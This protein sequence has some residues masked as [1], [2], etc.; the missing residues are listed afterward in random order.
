MT[1]QVNGTDQ[2]SA[3]RMDGISL[4]QT[5]EGAYNEMHSILQ[6]IRELAVQAQNSTLSSSDHGRDHPRSAS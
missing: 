5:A 3:T 4:V 2:A 6:R 1:A